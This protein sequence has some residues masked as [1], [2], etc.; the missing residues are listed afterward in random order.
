LSFPGNI[1]VD[2]G[3]SIVFPGALWNAKC[4]VALDNSTNESRA[5]LTRRKQRTLNG[6]MRSLTGR[7]KRIRGKTQSSSQSSI[8]IQSTITSD[9]QLSQELLATQGHAKME[10]AHTDDKKTVRKLKAQLIRSQKR[11][12]HAENQ[13]DL[14][15]TLTANVL[16]AW[17]HRMSIANGFELRFGLQLTVAAYEGVRRALGKDWSEDCGRY[18]AAM[19]PGSK[20]RVP[21]LPPY[22]RISRATDEFLEQ[23]GVQDCTRGRGTHVGAM[24]SIRESLTQADYIDGNGLGHVQIL[25]DAC[26]SLK[27]VQVVNV[28]TRGMNTL[29]FYNALSCMNRL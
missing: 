16:K 19:V 17:R 25:G 22:K 26:R 29:P 14:Q 12:V 23:L 11:T 13:L 2:D 6:M 9:S 7:C 24:T 3:G 10:V 21:V 28:C 4:T 1:G 5:K 15:K 20:I 27:E 18:V 8:Q